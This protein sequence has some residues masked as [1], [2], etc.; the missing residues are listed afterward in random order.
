MVKIVKSNFFI[1]LWE[2]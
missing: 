1:D 2:R